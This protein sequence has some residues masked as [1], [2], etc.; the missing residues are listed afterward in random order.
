MIYVDGS[1][2]VFFP[3][4]KQEYRAIFAFWYIFQQKVVF[5]NIHFLYLLVTY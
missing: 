3:M 4:N 1:F 5:K 2:Q